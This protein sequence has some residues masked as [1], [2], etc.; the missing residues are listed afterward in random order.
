MN[1]KRKGG[2]KEFISRF[3]LFPMFGFQV[4]KNDIKVKLKWHKA[5]FFSQYFFFVHRRIKSLF[6]FLCCFF[7][8]FSSSVFVALKIINIPDS[9]KIL[10][11][12]DIE[13]IDGRWEIGKVYF[14]NI[15]DFFN[16]L[17]TF[18]SSGNDF[19]QAFIDYY[20][21]SIFVTIL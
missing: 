19:C 8:A 7:H 18:K 10:Q 17:A 13:D 12:P 1:W 16:V 6:S 20:T 9:N 14:Y 21:I 4:K 2:L 15:Q 5:K 11:K 3:F